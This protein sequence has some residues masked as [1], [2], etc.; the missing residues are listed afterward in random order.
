MRS[1]NDSSDIPQ[2]IMLCGVFDRYD[3][4]YCREDVFYLTE[5]G[6]E[7]QQKPFLLLRAELFGKIAVV[8][9]TGDQVVPELRAALRCSVYQ[10]LRCFLNFLTKL[11]NVYLLFAY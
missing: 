10:L 1:P 11:I 4:G 3:S 7:F 2:G 5:Q 8:I 9:D 6:I